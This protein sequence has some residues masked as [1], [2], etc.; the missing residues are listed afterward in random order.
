M[1]VTVQ[2]NGTD[3]NPYHRLHLGFNPFPETPTEFN[4]EPIRRLGGDPIPDT[5]YIRK[6]L[7]GFSAEFIELVCS[8]F[9]K[10]KM[11]TFTVVMPPYTNEE[12][13]T[14]SHE[15]RE[16]MREELRKRKR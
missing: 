2:L 16:R 12:L 10:G 14:L 9:E 3:S 4:D 13:A 7:D 15:E 5:D 11:V 6:V 8:K 1:Q